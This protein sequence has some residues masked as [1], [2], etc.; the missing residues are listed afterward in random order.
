MIRLKSLR[1]KLFLWYVGSLLVVIT[2]FLLF[3]HYY[4]VPHAIHILIG[5]FIILAIAQFVTVY[6][7]T[8]SITLLSSKIKL[9]S[10][11]NLEE[12]ITGNF[13]E[14][15]IG[16]LADSFN[17]LLDRLHESFK[18]EQQFIADVA[19]ELKTPLTTIKSSFEIALNRPRTNEEYKRVIGEAITETTQLSQTLKNVLDLAW[20]K[21]P[22]GQK[23]KK[24]FNLTELITD[25]FEIAQKLAA[26]KKIEV[27]LSTIPNVF[28][29]GF[30]DKLARVLLNL[31]DNAIK[32]SPFAEKIEIILEKTPNKVLISVID[33]GPGIPEK[34]LP[35]IFDRFYRGSTTD[36]PWNYSAEQNRVLGNGLGLAI[37]KSIITL[38]QGEIKVKNNKGEGSTFIVVLPLT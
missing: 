2:Y 32:Y 27:K 8:K 31:I 30:K 10:S 24:K 12:K 26:K 14:D 23:T 33:N 7:I 6:K 3:I 37:A 35:H 38:H 25:L 28:I 34:D 15:E 22:E 1:T 16:E 36:K 9:I 18:R 19:H 4:A 11:E 29:T 13:G 20:S 21:A 5:L 17:N